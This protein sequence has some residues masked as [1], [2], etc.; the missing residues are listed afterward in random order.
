[1]PNFAGKLQ[2]LDINMVLRIELSNFFSIRDLLSIDFR[3]ANIHTRL[4]GELRD[5]VM[6]LRARVEM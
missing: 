3:A 2:K 5:N 4:A 1:M 6:E